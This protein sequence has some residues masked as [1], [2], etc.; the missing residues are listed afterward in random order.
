MRSNPLS[1]SDAPGQGATSHTQEFE[2]ATYKKVFWRVV[3]VFFLCYV[4][5]Y[6]DRVNI[7]F[8]KLQMLGDLKLD[9]NVYALGA[10]ILFWGYILFEVPSN[11]ILH[12][13]GARRWIARIMISWGLVSASLM[14]IEPL[15]Q[16]FHTGSPTMFYILRFLLGVCEAGFFPGIV[17][18]LNSWFPAQ[19]QNRVLAGFM[20][21]LPLSLC[22]GS[23][24]S[25]WLLENTQNFLGYRGWQWM[26]LL[27]GL[28]SVVL[29]F[30]VL[31]T[32]TD[33]IDK[34]GWLNNGEKALL[35][36]NITKENSTKEK[37][38]G[39]A[40]KNR[41]VWT[42]SFVLLTMLTGFYGLSF[43]LPSIIRAT[44]IKNSFHIGVI[45]AIP[46]AVA[47]VAM[48]ANAAHSN[49]TGER[50]L[51]AAIP[52]LMA[53]VALILSAKFSSN[54]PVSMFLITIA[55]SGIIGIMPIFWSFSGQLLSGV[56][57]AAGLAMIN[58]IGSL[59]GVTGA[60]ITNVVK[61]MT[62]DINN[63]TYALGVSLLISFLLILS[64]PRKLATFTPQ[65]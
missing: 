8:A 44:G 41:S 45:A 43:W 54:L 13:V 26:L 62:G 58:S 49:K 46:Y 40:F 35:K 21:A 42:L 19:K 38:F 60:M 6:L 34:A 47:G 27:E 55:A 59:S 20:V 53:G 37:N 36:T 32:L 9:D 22:L 63:G 31:F 4:V 28:P 18:Y 5:S 51:H 30:V 52:A 2:N 12:R 1:V 7:G 23:P 17:Y 11:I 64:L 56:A 29:G 61:N 50:R 65:Q 16:F 39:A 10:S 15:G 57:A 33:D 24:L 48:I 25:G 3:P 14:Y